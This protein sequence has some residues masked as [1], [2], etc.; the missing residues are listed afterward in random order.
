MTKL[1]ENFS[2]IPDLFDIQKTLS[3]QNYTKE[4]SHLNTE[5][6]KAQRFLLLLKEAFGDVNANFVED[7]LQGVEKY[8]KTKKKDVLLKGKI[9]AL[10]GNLIIEF[11]KDLKKTFP[12]VM[13]QLKRYTACLWSEEEEKR[14]GYLCLATDGLD[15]YIFSPKT[16]KPLTES[17]FPEDI[18]LEES[19]AYQAYF[20]FD[21]YFF[22]KEILHPKTEEFEKDFGIKSP[23]FIFPFKELR[24]ILRQVD[25]KSESNVIYE[26]WD[27]YL[28][29]TYG[30]TV[31]SKDLFL[32]LPRLKT[33]DSQAT[34]SLMS[35]VNA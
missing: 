4:I 12:E 26:T 24:D 14:V 8:V 31:G 20:W 35:C 7:Y 19:D 15:F 32:T 6:A 30:G 33:G 5:S 22:R 18:S 2:R 17:L 25:D 29:I 34:H 9:D 28:R 21:R 16:E 27:K 13:E 3:I 1:H 11:E 23:A 10:Y